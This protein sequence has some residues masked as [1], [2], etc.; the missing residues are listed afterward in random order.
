MLVLCLA[1]P[2]HAQAPA[3][4]DDVQLPTRAIAKYRPILSDAPSTTIHALTWSPDGKTIGLVVSSSADHDIQSVRLW[5]SSTSRLRADL[6]EGS[7]VTFAPD[8]KTVAWGGGWAQSVQVRDLVAGRT[9]HKLQSGMATT[10][11]VF[12]PDGRSLLTLSGAMG[13]TLIVWDPETGKKRF[14]PEASVLGFTFTPDGR[15]LAVAAE[16]VDGSTLTVYET[17]TGKVRFTRELTIL[18][19]GPQGLPLDPGALLG[20][21]PDGKLL[22]VAGERATLYDADTGKEQRRVGDEKRV[23]KSLAFSRDGKRLATVDVDVNGVIPPPRPKNP[24]DL[25]LKAVLAAGE[26][27]HVWDVAT[28]KKTL[29]VPGHDAGTKA[30]AFAPDEKSLVTAGADFP[31]GKLE[32]T[33]GAVVGLKGSVRYWD[34]VTGKERRRLSA[35]AE[36]VNCL[37]FSP[38]GK[39][40]ATAGNDGLLI[41][42]KAEGK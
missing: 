6:R 32:G 15:S 29:E 7:A 38:D 37:T 4:R 11:V 24:K 9:L 20:C 22:A 10:H 19:S 14:S 18:E 35:H 17:A 8:G 31:A 27:V 34:L 26:M 16:S 28:G 40:L 2:L 12:A 30:V 41:I 1:P 42:W 21:S 39:A 3:A 25:D 5:D 36:G 23:T 33:I 13:R